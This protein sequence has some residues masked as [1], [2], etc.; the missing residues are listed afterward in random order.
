MSKR[1]IIKLSGE[2]LGGNGQV[3]DFA[4]AQTAARVLA[5]ASRM[6]YQIGVVIGAGNIWRGRQGLVLD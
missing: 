5:Q 6:S 3:F 1:I 2:A 4:Q